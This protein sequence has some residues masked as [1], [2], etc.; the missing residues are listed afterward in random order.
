MLVDK[1]IQR[2]K[3]I[4]HSGRVGLYK[5]SPSGFA[6]FGDGNRHPK[7]VSPPSRAEL[8][9]FQCKLPKFSVSLPLRSLR[10]CGFLIRLYLSLRVE[11]SETKH[12]PKVWIIARYWDCFTSYAFQ[13]RFANAMTYDE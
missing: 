7:L 6:S 5:Q 11:R 4:P 8:V 10:L 12:S 9:I 3:K 2:I 13:A 1:C